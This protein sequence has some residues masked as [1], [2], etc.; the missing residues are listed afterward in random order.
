MDKLFRHTHLKINLDNLIHNVNEIKKFIKK[1]VWI[2]T[3]LKADAYG[4]GAK[5]VASTLFNNGFNYFLVST[6]LEALELKISNKNYNVF[7]MGHTPDEYLEEIV[8]TDLICT[9]LLIYL[10]KKIR[11]NIILDLRII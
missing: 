1:D 11:I 10:D 7:I 8:N 6:L 4:H 3:V 2:G 5:E 9:I